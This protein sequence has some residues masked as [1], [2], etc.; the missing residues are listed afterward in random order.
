MTTAP[1]S[2]IIS[3]PNTINP[4]IKWEHLHPGGGLELLNYRQSEE[5]LLSWSTFQCFATN[6]RQKPLG[7][8]ER[9]V[10]F[11]ERP[12]QGAKFNKVFYSLCGFTDTPK[13]I[14]A[15]SHSLFVEHRS[16]TCYFLIKHRSFIDAFY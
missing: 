7:W 11:R 13:P 14:C 10:S 6:W 16:V 4:Y 15:F 2:A 12:P 9:K 8:L 3:N 5:I 1:A